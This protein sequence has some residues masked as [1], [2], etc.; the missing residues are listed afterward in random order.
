MPRPAPAALLADLDEE[1]RLLEELFNGLSTGDWERPTPTAGWAVRHQVA[2]LAWTERAV[3][4]AVE[5]LAAFTVLR[6]RF[7][8][9]SRRRRPPDAAQRACGTAL[10]FTLVATCRSHRQGRRSRGTA[11]RGNP[12]AHHPSPSDI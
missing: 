12:S 4:S 6:E 8:Q 1:G 10:N 11:A 5:D 3:L 9:D 7:A 2:H